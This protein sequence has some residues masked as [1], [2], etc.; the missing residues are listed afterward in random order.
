[1]CVRLYFRY[2]LNIDAQNIPSNL[3]INIFF[4]KYIFGIFLVLFKDFRIPIEV[5]SQ[6]IANCRKS[7]KYNHKIEEKRQFDIHIYMTAH[8]PGLKQ[9]FQ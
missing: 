9:A 5:Q 7:S 6:I 4:P 3:E 2:S 8:F 1:V